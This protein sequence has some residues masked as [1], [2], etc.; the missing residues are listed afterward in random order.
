MRHLLLI[1]V[2][3]INLSFFGI[4]AAAKPNVWVYTDM[5]DPRDQREGG[6]PFNDPDDIV[7][8]APL[9][10][11]AN[12]FNI[13]TIVV[14]STNR[15]YLGDS[16]DFVNSVLLDAYHHDVSYLNDAFGGYQNTINFVRSS[17]T[18]VALPVRF[19]PST[20]YSDLTN[21]ETVA[22]LIEYAEENE[23]YVLCWGPLTEP[24]IAV[25]HCLDTQN[26]KA[27]EHMTFMGHWT[28]SFIA[29]GT[30]ETPYAV[31]NCKDDAQ[32][33]RF[34]HDQA[35]LHQEIKYIEL[36]SVGQKGI[37]D[38]SAG[39]VR[40]EAFNGSRLGQ[41]YLH[42]KRY[43]DKPDMSDGS[44][45][46]LLTEAFGV[47]L[48]DYP[49]DGTLTQEIEV[50]NRDKFHANAHAILDDLLLR[51]NTAAEAKSPFPE[52]FIADHFTY[53]FQFL[54]ERYYMHAPYDF[55]YQFFDKQDRVVRTGSL[56]AGK[57]QLD[58]SDLKQGDYNVQ[59]RSGGVTQYFGLEKE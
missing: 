17:A 44:T 1:L 28:M 36:G 14:S 19:D 56:K 16:M 4:V 38:G 8:M 5:S 13:E 33:C 15:K 55:S 26:W 35:R 6:H 12:R 45:F 57:Y 7:T 30:P 50:S 43:G 29:Q 47:T 58:L 9:L 27:L 18:Q 52:S 46:W 34:I 20:D 3:S 2:V 53:V 42:A 41:I 10:L 11:E 23:V 31:A 59:V 54:D 49:H 21:H 40:L 39:F 51:S 32:A 22:S 37:V 25:K 24:A 48:E